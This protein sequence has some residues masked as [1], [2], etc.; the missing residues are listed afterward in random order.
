MIGNICLCANVFKGSANGGQVAHA[1][2]NNS[3][4]RWVVVVDLGQVAVPVLDEVP[5]PSLLNILLFVN[6]SQT[7]TNS[8]TP[9]SSGFENLLDRLAEI[10]PRK[11]AVPSP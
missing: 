6:R 1:I 7:V 2:I 3:N 9:M 11:L 8:S 10:R 5:A 4:L